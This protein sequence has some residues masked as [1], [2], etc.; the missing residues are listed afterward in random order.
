MEARPCHTCHIGCK[1]MTSFQKVNK[2]IHSLCEPTNAIIDLARW[3]KVRPNDATLAFYS[4]VIF[5]MVQ[6]RM[7]R[8]N[9]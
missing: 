1:E 7:S 5:I 9:D 6:R 4:R 2:Y 3:H 8:K